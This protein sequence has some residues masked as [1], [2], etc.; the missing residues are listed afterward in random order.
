MEG[1]LVRAR[2][3]RTAHAGGRRARPP[4]GAGHL[5]VLRTRLRRGVGPVGGAVFTGALLF[6][7]FAM[8]FVQ[9][10]Q[11]DWTSTS[12]LLSL[13]FLLGL[14]VT[15]CTSSWQGGTEARTATR[16]THTCAVRGPLSRTLLSMAPSLL[17]TLGGFGVATAVIMGATWRSA[18]GGSPPYYQVAYEAAL[19]VALVCVAHVLGDLIPLRAAPLLVCAG[20]AVL[21]WTSLNLQ[22]ERVESSGVAAV[23]SP[24]WLGHPERRYAGP[25]VPKDPSAD[26]ADHPATWVHWAAVALF[27]IVAVLAIAVHARRWIVSGL[28]AL[29]LASN[30]TALPDSDFTLP[31]APPIAVRCSADAPAACLSDDRKTYRRQLDKVVRHFAG[32]LASVNGAPKRFLATAETWTGCTRDDEA[33]DWTAGVDLSVGEGESFTE[34]ARHIADPGCRAGGFYDRARDTDLI[35][36]VTDWLLPPKYLNKHHG[37]H[38]YPAARVDPLV[39]RLTALPHPTRAAWLTE[40]LSAVRSGGHIPD[41]PPTT[42]AAA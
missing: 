20:V 25:G 31:S 30:S 16:W 40:Y 34:L 33:G 9:S 15:L 7:A 19:L 3:R 35:H 36:A 10:W 41:L 17:W 11:G 29:A 24:F 26:L 37:Y 8:S 2:R 42:K 14:P 5:R 22:A 13:S 28:I 32:R 21:G 23:L 18:T 1:F 12:E 4:G 6:P 38:R 27:L 39:D